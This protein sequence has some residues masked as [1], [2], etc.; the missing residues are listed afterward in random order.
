M[1]N[2]LTKRPSGGVTV[3]AST[4]LSQLVSTSTS[5]VQQATSSQQA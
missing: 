2:Q 5:S 1:L 4:A 3:D